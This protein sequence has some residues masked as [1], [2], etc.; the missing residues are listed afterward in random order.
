[1]QPVFFRP[2]RQNDSIASMNFY[3]KSSLAPE[4]IVATIPEV[5]RSLDPGPLAASRGPRFPPRKGD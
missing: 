5:I 2:Y 3:V 4:Q 1:M